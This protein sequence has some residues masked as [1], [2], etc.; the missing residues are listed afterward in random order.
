MITYG[1]TAFTRLTGSIPRTVNDLFSSTV[2]PDI[3]FKDITSSDEH[4]V[5]ALS[6]RVEALCDWH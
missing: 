4:V 2:S 5:N 6:D 3:D 1:S